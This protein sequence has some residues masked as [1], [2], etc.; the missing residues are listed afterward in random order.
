MN[1]HPVNLAV[2]FLL[3][4]AALSAYAA[5]GWHR[6]EGWMRWVLAI[7]IP[8]IAATIWGIFRVPNDPGPATVAVPGLVRLLIEA[9]FFILAVLALFQMQHEKLGWTMAALLVL[10]YIVSYDRVLWIIGR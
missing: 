4:L 3:E 6:G 7:I 5:W 10:H 1:S 9:V 2:R 8:L